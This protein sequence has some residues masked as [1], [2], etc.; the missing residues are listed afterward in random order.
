[1]SKRK[2]IELFLA[3]N[4]KINFSY[5]VFNKGHWVKLKVL[6]KLSVA[7]SVTDF[8]CLFATANLDKEKGKA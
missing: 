3:V 1:M 5:N 6:S 8:L 7:N 4:S 2:Q